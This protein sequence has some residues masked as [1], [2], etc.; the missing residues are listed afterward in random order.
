MI[1]FVDVWSS[2]GEEA[3]LR[4]AS[5]TAQAGQVTALV[6]PSGSGKSTVLR[7]LMGF[8]QADKGAIVIDGEEVAT[9]G[10]RRWRIIRRKMGMVFQSSALFD[11]MTVCQ[12]VGFYPHFVE[13]QPWRKVRVQVLELL[14]ELG[15]AEAADKLPGEL[16]GGMQRRVALARSL[17]YRPKILLYD[18]PTTGLDPH[19]TVVVT[20]LIAEMNARYGV[21]SVVVSHDLPSIHDIADHVVL[22]D[23]GRTV[24]VGSPDQLL[25]SDDPA[26]SRF[27]SIWREQIRLYAAELAGAAPTP[28]K[29]FRGE[30]RAE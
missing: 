6:G 19:M 4:G 7:L 2:Y 21:T 22:V 15:L 26:V 23:A 24:P 20:E 1:K 17:I 3:I 18:E 13:R 8:W 29:G 25:H 28:H 27:A 9:A 11:S 30:E 10:E 14:D 12:N 16:S 5:F